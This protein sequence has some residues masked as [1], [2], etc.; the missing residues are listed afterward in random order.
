MSRCIGA[1]LWDVYTPPAVSALPVTIV[2][3][4]RN[5][6][7]NLP[8]CLSRLDRFT[9]IVV[10][11][12]GSTDR[13]PEIVRGSRAKLVDFK[14]DG[15]FPKKRN[16]VLRHYDF[17]T[18]WVMFLDA[19]E[20][21]DDEFCDA[22]ERILPT[23][24][25]AGFWLTYRNWFMG[26]RLLHGTPFRK[27]SLMRVGMG[28]FE[29]IDEERWSNLDIEVHEHPILQGTAGEI[30]AAI[31]HRDYKSLEHYIS[32]HN[33]YSSW[34]ARRF[35]DLSRRGTLND[36]PL[37]PRQLRKYKS[38]DR[39]WCAPGYFL[40]SYV[41]RLGFLDG[42]VG[43]HFA[44]AKAVYFWQIRLKILEIRAQGAGGQ[45]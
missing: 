34:E 4:V 18:P 36:L 17:K 22:L 28:E 2:V 12:S 13:T 42:S 10:V 23:T 11:D 37:T 27:L 35:I 24:T 6:E 19:D 39:W 20:F 1:R 41:R 16:W 31:D 21:V 5:E 9:E 30:E 14:W 25:H 38:L 15:K 33:E 26:K 45:S 29:R 44:L 3:P 40:D 43:F 8:E 7:R 32:R